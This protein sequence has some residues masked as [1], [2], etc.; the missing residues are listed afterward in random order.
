M[1]QAVERFE[2][3]GRLVALVLRQQADLG[4]G[5]HFLTPDDLTQQLAYMDN[6]AGRVISPHMHNPSLRQVTQ[7]GEVLFIR[8]GRLLVELFHQDKSPLAQVVLGPGDLVLLCGAPHGFKVLER[9]QMIEIKQGPYM[10]AQEK[11]YLFAD[12]K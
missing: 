12:Q 5:V 3:Q 10:G 1:D 4:P 7:T 11:H 8:S 6:P 2:D 9:C